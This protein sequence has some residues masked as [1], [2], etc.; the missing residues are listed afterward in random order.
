[1]IDK[2]NFSNDD[3]SHEYNKDT[4]QYFFNNIYPKH[5]YFFNNN[6]SIE[7]TS[8]EKEYKFSEP[9]LQHY[10]T[11]DWDGIVLIHERLSMQ[12]INADS[13][14]R[15]KISLP[16]NLIQLTDYKSHIDSTLFNQIQT[17]DNFKMEFQR[18]DGYHEIENKKYIGVQV[19]KLMKGAPPYG[20]AQIRYLDADSGEF[21]PFTKNL[22]YFDPNPHGYN[23]YKISL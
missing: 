9:K 22:S 3:F 12:I 14:Q 19:S 8:S 18:F 11:P 4:M 15:H 20:L 13:S 23:E 17:Y 7:W 2:I 6:S 1:M 16:E 10:V 21:L 5:R